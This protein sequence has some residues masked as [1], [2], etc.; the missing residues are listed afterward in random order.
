MSRT[1]VES[2]PPQSFARAQRDASATPTP[3]MADYASIE[4]LQCAAWE[5]AAVLKAI[6]DSIDMAER[7]PDRDTMIVSLANLGE[8][9]LRAA[10]DALEV[11]RYRP[12]KAA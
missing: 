6:A 2:L 4:A 9:S 5:G 1:T 7:G 10:A 11:D 12:A 3:E 8:R